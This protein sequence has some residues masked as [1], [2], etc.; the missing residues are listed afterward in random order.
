MNRVD[1][2]NRLRHAHASALEHYEQVTGRA[3]SRPSVLTIHPTHD[4]V[5]LIRSK[6]DRVEI[7]ASL[8]VVSRLESLW[9]KVLRQSAQLPK[10]KRMNIFD[11]NEAID[12]SLIWLMLHE[13][14]HEEIGHLS[15]VGSAGLSETFLNSELG[16]TKRSSLSKP[17][18]LDGMTHQKA[19]AIRRCLE[20]Q[21]D[22]RALE[23]ML[24]HYSNEAWEYKRFSITTSIAVMVLIDDQDVAND[25][26][27]TH[28]Y[29]ATR[30]FHLIGILGQAWKAQHASGRPRLNDEEVKA[31]HKNVVIPAVLDFFMIATA[32]GN[33]TILQSWDDMDMFFKDIR[34]LQAYTEYDPTQFQ[35]Q[36][37]KEYASLAD[38]N[39]E[40][41]LLL[42]PNAYPAL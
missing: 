39:Q 7:V 1:A 4:F 9:Q 22:H 32:V 36:C 42:E 2:E 21:A 14:Y 26:Q 10:N 20:L 25:I 5:A 41:V 18:V 23:I 11:I 31:Y 8:G 37:A 30:A 12:S 19:I 34:M 6:K 24:D 3:F 40:A 27:R 38:I 13:L 33:S 17:S 16:L 29:A 28:P 35:T 15:L